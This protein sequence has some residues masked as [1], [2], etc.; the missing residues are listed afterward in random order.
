MTHEQSVSD[1]P[2]GSNAVRLSARQWIVA[3]LIIL[4]VVIATPVIWN[5]IEPFDAAVDF[6]VPYDLSNDYWT[7]QRLAESAVSRDRILVIGDSV[8]WGEY[9]DP[10]HTLSH[11]L[12]QADGEFRFANGGLNG[13]HP[14]ALEGL[15]KYYAA[16]VHDR[17]VIL[18]CNLLWMSSTERD[19]QSDK[20][21]PFNHPQLVPQFVPSIPCYKAPV[22]ERMGIAVDRRIAYRRWVNHLRVAYFG[23]Q[24]IASWTLEHPYD[25]PIRQI[26]LEPPEPKSEPH[27]QPISWLQR[28]IQTQDMP[29]IDLDTSL[30]WQAFR[31]TVEL[32]RRR[33]NRLFVIVG[34]FNEHM[35]TGASRDRYRTM[36]GQVEAWLGE[37]R[38]AHFAATN[39]PSQEYAD[40]SHPLSAGY[41]RIAEELHNDSG[42]QRWLGD[43]SDDS[44]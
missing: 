11:Y 12:N 32:L 4:L 9:V 36:V 16:E 13:T 28:G 17:R 10:Q 33:G 18:H 39:L 40:A 37:Q 30:Q 43:R 24:D 27:S 2:F 21:L 3:A 15:V 25:N 14:L 38:V 22:E 23:S 6:R 44:E 26:R 1:I 34:P 19:L 42:F 29:W 7:Y 35:L 5:R 8:V 31:A 41:A 20:E